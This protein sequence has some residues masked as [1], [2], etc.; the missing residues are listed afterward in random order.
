LLSPY[1]GGVILA[2][3]VG[4]TH[5]RLGLFTR[6]RGK[7]RAAR[8]THYPSA[9]HESFEAILDTF[10]TAGR[11]RVDCCAIGV[12]G[13]VVNG[14][15]MPV[16]LHWSI[17]ARRVA[18]RLSIPRVALINDMEATAWGVAEVEPRRKINLTPS[19]R[20]H[21]GNA[22]LV[23]VGT[24]LGMAL[25]VWD[26]Q[27]HRPSAGEGGHQ[28]FAPHDDVEIALL[29]YLQRTHARVSAER[30]LSGPGFSALYAFFRD[31]G[32]GDPG[33]E[34]RRRL[35]VGEDPN[36]VIC[37]TGMNGDDPVA[38]RVVDLFVAVLG[39]VAGDLALVSRA[40]G[41]VYLAGAITARLIPK[42]REGRFLER[43]RDKGRLR[44]LV[45]RIPVRVMTEP[46]AALLGAAAC[47]E[48]ESGRPARAARSKSKTKRK[49]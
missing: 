18:R 34:M 35:A 47:A 40:V 15:S 5:A 7:L 27:R 12:A 24:G 46:R 25:L 11:E 42:L 31:N 13:P 49:R 45:E 14:R 22:A 9:E 10:L 38:V 26:G 16:N 6:T 1:N 19:L 30:V 43:F 23:A 32:W 29:R 17:D 3:D 4:G 28:G 48:S 2:A 41:G 37:E 21:P 36:A 8:E 44:G 33:P 20:A 39:S